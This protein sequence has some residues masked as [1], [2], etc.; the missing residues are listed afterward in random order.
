MKKLVIVVLSLIL[1]GCAVN[2]KYAS[3][4]TSE[5]SYINENVK[6][7]CPKCGR[8]ISFDN[9]Q[10]YRNVI[11]KEVKFLIICPNCGTKSRYR[12]CK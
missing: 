7:Y 6:Y 4:K 3:I 2:G 1:G 5:F 11:N 9:W 8:H 12:I 10:L